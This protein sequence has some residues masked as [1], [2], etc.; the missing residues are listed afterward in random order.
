MFSSSKLSIGKSKHRNVS[1]DWK[2]LDIRN[3]SYVGQ[4]SICSLEIYEN[5]P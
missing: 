2:G 1:N 5:W 3:K 4:K